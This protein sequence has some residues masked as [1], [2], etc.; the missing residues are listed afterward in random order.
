MRLPSLLRVHLWKSLD[1]PICEMGTTM[2]DNR[3][4]PGN[5]LHLLLFS[6]SAVSN[7]LWPHG[8]Q[9]AKLPCPSPSPGVCSNSSCPLSWWC[10]PTI[11]SSVILFSSCPQSFPSSWS[12]PMNWLFLSGGQS[13]GASV[14]VLPVNIQDWFPLAL[15]GLIFLQS[16]GLKSLSPGPQFESINFLVLSLL[17]G[18]TLTFITWLLEKPQ[19]WL[20][21]P[22]LAKWC[23]CFSIH[24]LG[25]S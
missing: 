20:Y 16:K 25:L 3:D 18:P 2:H 5:D 15:T 21:T 7:S 19:L 14:S 24:Y 10:H 4:A 13:I 17:Y 8:L 22:L 11:S 12:F 6:H 23:L 1:S 9:Y